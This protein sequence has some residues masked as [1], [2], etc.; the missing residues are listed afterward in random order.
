MYF[1][2]KV[3]ELIEASYIIKRQMRKHHRR[4]EKRKFRIDDQPKA[5]SIKTEGP[6]DSITPEAGIDRAENEDLPNKTKQ[7]IEYA[8]ENPLHVLKEVF[9]PDKLVFIIDE[10]KD[11]LHI[12]L[13]ADCTAY[14]EAEQR[15]NLITFHDHL[16]LLIE[17][18]FVL[19]LQYTDD[20]DLKGKFSSTYKPCLLNTTQIANPE[21]VIAAFFKKF[22]T[23]YINR[24]LDSWYEASISYSGDWRDNVICLQQVW[25]IYRNVLCLVK[26]AT[27]ILQTPKQTGYGK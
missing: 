14:D 17:A 8:G 9:N 25:D 23:V 16:L 4:R 2:E 10:V 5:Q 26:S 11:W 7:L 1:Y 3:E 18:L 24:E 6:F 12:G 15:S 13:S 27:H 20:A 22:P 19:N 21:Q